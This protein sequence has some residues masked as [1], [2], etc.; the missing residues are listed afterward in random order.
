MGLPGVGYDRAHSTIAD[1]S[2]GPSDSI[3]G[4]AP[5]EEIQTTPGKGY[6]IFER[7]LLP[8]VLVTPTITTQAVYGNGLKAFGST[9]GTILSTAGATT[10]RGGGLVLLTDGT[11]ND[12]ISI[13][14]IALPFQIIQGGGDVFFEAR[15]K[16]LGIA[17]NAQGLFCGLIEQQTLSAIIPIVAAGTMADANYVG[18]FKNEAAATFNAV[19]K[20]NGITQVTVKA[21]AGTLVADTYVKTGFYYNDTAK[22][23]RMYVNGLQVGADYSMA[24]AAGTDFPNDV[25][26]GFCFAMIN[27][28]GAAN[29]DTSTLNWY[30]AAQV[31]PT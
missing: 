26:L 1:T 8:G 25:P 23:L 12:A 30:R 22:V 14:N 28:S 19:Y 13:A 11:D 10:G 6:H 31:T 15:W 18:F 21:T 3:W 24:S 9:G 7:F 29:L 27:G 16:L 20:A 17:A 4:V 2:S 5:I